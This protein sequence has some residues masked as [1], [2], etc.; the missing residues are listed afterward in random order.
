MDRSDAAEHAARE[1]GREAPKAETVPEVQKRVVGH[2][3][4]QVTNLQ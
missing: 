1:S 3:A 4:E 2:A